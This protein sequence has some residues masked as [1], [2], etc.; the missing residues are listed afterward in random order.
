MFILYS[1]KENLHIV[2][3]HILYTPLTAAIKWY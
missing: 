1:V 3:L 2:Q